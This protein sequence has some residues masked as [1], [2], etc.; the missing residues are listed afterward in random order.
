MR[1]GSEL[2]TRPVL[3]T[4]ALI[5]F[6][7]ALVFLY[8]KLSLVVSN[9][10]WQA[11]LIG[12]QPLIKPVERVPELT[13]DS[14]LDRYVITSSRSECELLCNMQN[15]DELKNK[16]SVKCRSGRDPQTFIIAIPDNKGLFGRVSKSIGSGSIN[17][18][19]KGKVEVIN[20][21]CELLDV[22][23]ID[24]CDQEGDKWVCRQK[25]NDVAS[26]EISVL[27][28]GENSCAISIR[29][30]LGGGGYGGG[31]SGTGGEW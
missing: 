21:D 6:V 18:M 31:G 7:A 27:H 29:T 20:L 10:C 1:K 4:F 19:F 13:F 16:C 23:G 17:W 2:M 15:N 24:E 5:L 9:P 26:R 3:A 11:V 25:G 22:F 28:Y 14:C 12:L 30:E 8:W